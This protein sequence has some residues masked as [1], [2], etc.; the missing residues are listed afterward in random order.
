MHLGGTRSS[1]VLRDED[2]HSCGFCQV[3]RDRTER[4]Q[5]ELLE[6]DRSHML[7][8]VAQSQPLTQVVAQLVKMVQRQYPETIA[9]VLLLS[10]GR[11]QQAGAS[12]L[13]ESFLEALTTEA[14]S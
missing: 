3:T 14:A 7:E 13:P 8:M 10:E 4:K 5:A 12:N 2:G 1:T 11:L 9:S 6:Q